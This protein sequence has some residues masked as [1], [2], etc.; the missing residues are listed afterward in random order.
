MKQLE[1]LT[2]IEKRK[3][4]LRNKKRASFSAANNQ[5]KL[6]KK[7]QV[8][9]IKQARK[10]ARD[11]A[12]IIELVHEVKPGET[13]Q[14]ISN[15]FDS[16]SILR[17]FN[18]ADIAEIHISTWAITEAG[19]LSLKKLSDEGVRIYV[20]LDTTHSY[21]WV[22]ESG[23]YEL[24]NENVTFKFTENHTKFQLF[25]FKEETYLS[26]IGSMNLSLNPRWENIEITCNPDIYHFYKDWIQSVMLNQTQA[27]K[28]IG[29]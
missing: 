24:L 18:P 22:F 10:I 19:I 28:R 5:V 23:A 17:S 25:K 3:E 11:V 26:F 14:L 20:L 2:I 12:T 4:T 1:T 9:E 7:L 16:P 29:L 13:L 6:I 21:K 27:Q 15:K 8:R